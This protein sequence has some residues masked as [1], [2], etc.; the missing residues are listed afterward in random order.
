[1]PLNIWF[2]KSFSVTYNLLTL[3]RHGD[4]ARQLHLF[5]SHSVENAMARLA[6]DTWH[7]EPELSGQDYVDW[8][9]RFCREH[10]IDLF[11]PGKATI[12][13]AYRVD[14]FLAQGTRVL[15][16]ADADNLVLLDQKARFSA[17][18]DPAL[19]PTAETVE[20]K[21]LA[22]FD[23]AYSQLRTRHARLCLKPSVSVFG[24][25]FRMLDEER[26]A[27]QHVL[28]GEEQMLNLAELRRAMQDKEDCKPS[29]LLM[30]F[31]GGDE[32][33]VDCL[34]EHGALLYSV[35]RRK[36]GVLSA[37]QQLDNHAGIAAMCV[38]LSEQFKLNGL[39]NIQFR[40]G[41]HGIRVLEINARPSG[42]VPL[43]CAA[44]VNLPYQAVVRALSEE[45]RAGFDLPDAASCPLPYGIFL[46][47]TMLPGLL[48]VPA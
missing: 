33:S 34:A 13:I 20:I 8:C 9:L 24:L 36:T 47:Q 48:D 17:A 11:V 10:A 43:A 15:L 19:T 7:V 26:D 37:P 1:M 29:L 39:F 42:G 4:P 31:L 5:A 12:N 22:E 18:V 35:Q 41:A 27:L 45:D 3:I 21:N 38:C 30:E 46:H 6:A 14:E 2:N 23:A 28:A 25:G 40:E 44:G 32:W 16:C